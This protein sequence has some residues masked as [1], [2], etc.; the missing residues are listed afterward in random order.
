MSQL[1]Q[2]LRQLGRLRPDDSRSATNEKQLNGPLLNSPLLNGPL[3]NGPLL[4]GQLSA[5]VESISRSRRQLKNEAAKSLGVTTKEIHFSSLLK[6]IGTPNALEVAESIRQVRKDLTRTLG[7]LQASIRSLLIERQLIEVS[8]EALG[9]GVIQE[10]Y[11]ESGE[12]LTIH[13]ESH[14]ETRS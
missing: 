3:V 2:T 5:E 10:K 13:P 11:D 6:R 14:L 9:V 1:Q 7:I 12:R 8:L 4:L